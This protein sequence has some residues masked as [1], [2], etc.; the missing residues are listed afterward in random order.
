MKE[1]RNE[2]EA[3]WS[4]HTDA[5]TKRHPRT[6]NEAFGTYQDTPLHP[7]APSRV[8]WFWNDVCILL[9]FIGLLGYGAWRV[10]A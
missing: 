6:L 4:M 2:R 5:T 1:L 7:M 9:I 3:N 8:S 10:F